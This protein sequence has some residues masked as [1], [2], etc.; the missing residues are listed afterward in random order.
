M[1]DQSA[2]QL[3][4]QPPIFLYQA[5]PLIFR[6]YFSRW[7]IVVGIV[8]FCLVFYSSGAVAMIHDVAI[9]RYMEWSCLCESMMTEN[10]YKPWKQALKNESIVGSV[11]VILSE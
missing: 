1:Y 5:K 6:N 7:L 2:D 3:T 10:M 8:Q 9:Y 11:L 4:Y